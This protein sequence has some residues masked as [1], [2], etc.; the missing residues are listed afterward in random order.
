MYRKSITLPYN[1]KARHC[2]ARNIVSKKHLRFL[3]REAFFL[4]YFNFLLDKIEFFF[5]FIIMDFIYLE[6]LKNNH[7][8]W[9]LLNAEKSPFVISFLNRVFIE[10]QLRGIKESQL[11]EKM[12]DYILHLNSIYGEDAYP[13]KVSDYLDDWSDDSRGWLRKYYPRFGD[14]AEYDITPAAEKVIE[15]LRSF[16]KKEF[17]GTESRLLL[18]FQMLK[19]LVNASET[20]PEKRINELER[21]KK[22]ID[23][24]INRVREGLAN[25]FDLRQIKESFWRIEEEIRNLMSDFREV[26]ENFRSLDRK[27]REKIST[28]AQVKGQILDDIFA[29]HDIIENS[30]QGKSFSAFWYF[31]MSKKRQFDMEEAVKKI[32]SIKGLNKETKLSSLGSIKY[33]LLDA[34]DRVKKTL[35]NL[36][37]QLRIFL[38]EKKWLENRRIMD[39][40]KSIEEKAIDIRSNPPTDKN[41]FLIDEVHPSVNLPMERRLFSPPQQPP[42]MEETLIEGVA[43]YIPEALYNQHYVDEKELREII[44]KSLIDRE[45]VTLRDISLTFPIKKGLSEIITYIV[46]AGKNLDALI[47][48]SKQEIIEYEDRKK[49]KKITIPLIIYTR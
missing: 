6:S 14:E 16:E 22:E 12:E 31:L 25:P 42:L 46:I 24:E 35:S 17:I 28:G 30:E 7:P 8:A 9:R 49:T 36:N 44:R 18:I 29:E 23:E 2:F 34:G 37:E 26:E 41:F 19:D 40:I 3:E 15:W 10:P 47:D 43:D 33:N 45:Q 27:T 48:V 32:L 13:R 11:R 20:D 38:D 21:E 4:G 5:Q 1:Y 39:L